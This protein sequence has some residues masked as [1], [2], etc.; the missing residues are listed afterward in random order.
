VRRI[1]KI[2]ARPGTSFEE[3]LHYGNAVVAIGIS[4][5]YSFVIVK[6]ESNI[7]I[8]IY[9]L[10]SQLAL[11]KYKYGVPLA[12]YS[13]PLFTQPVTHL[14]DSSPAHCHSNKLPP[15]PFPAD[16]GP[17]KPISTEIL[18]ELMPEL[19]A[20]TPIRQLTSSTTYSVSFLITPIIQ[21]TSNSFS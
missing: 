14:F 15:I 1:E 17:P 9:V 21:T 8:Q 16:A 4:L 6:V 7:P 12:S 11:G 5:V 20:D 10:Q 18:T 2:G 13:M 19:L 3:W